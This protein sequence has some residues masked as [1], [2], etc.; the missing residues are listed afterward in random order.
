MRVGVV[1]CGYWGSKHVRV[2]T[3]LADV[4][5][6][7]VI[8]QREQRRSELQRSF[9]TVTVSEHLSDAL[10]QVDAVVIALPPGGHADAALQALRAG[11]HVLVEK[12]MATSVAD[13][14]LMI[15]EAQSRGLVLMVGHTFEYNSAVRHLRAIVESGDLGTLF[16]IDTARLNLGLYQ[17]DVNVISDLAPHDISIINYLLDST[18]DS[19]HASGSSHAHAYLEDVA[20]LQLNYSSSG[21]KAHVHVS[22]LDPRKVRR[23]TVVGSRRVAVYNDLATEE[24]IRIYDRGVNSGSSPALHTA[25]LSYRYGDVVS[26]FVPFIEPLQVE[27]QHFI[28]CIL[29]GAPPYTDG[30]SGLAVVRVLEAAQE[31][32]RSGAPVKVQND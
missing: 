25:P 22:W 12:P 23:G 28:D 26:P 20:Y 19:V 18:P 21:V 30:H 13:C 8:D 3:G 2:L 6:V 16:Y 4:D 32:L 15:K 27:D 7:C 9:P 31:S 14:E 29:Q 1:G 17:P 24:P 11:K 10:D 5:Q